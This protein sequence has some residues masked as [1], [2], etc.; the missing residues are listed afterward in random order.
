MLMPGSHTGA[1]SWECAG[2]EVVVSGGTWPAGGPFGLA[3]GRGGTCRYQRTV[4]VAVVHRLTS[5]TRLADVVPL[6]EAD[7]RIQVVYTWAPGSAFG[8]GVSEYLRG[9]QAAPSPPAGQPY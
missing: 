8:A 1:S 7:R 2:L 4:V 3:A 6:L 9:W 5:A